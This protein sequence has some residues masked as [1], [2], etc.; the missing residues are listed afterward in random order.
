MS[1]KRL[2]TN[3][4]RKQLKDSQKY[5][6]RRLKDLSAIEKDELL[7]ILAKKAGIF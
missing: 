1:V 6:G 5:R 3:K 4:Q 7:E 2:I